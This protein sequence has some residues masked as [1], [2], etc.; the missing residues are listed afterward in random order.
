MDS[1]NPNSVR[2]L[3][4]QGLAHHKS[5]RFAEAV[6]LYERVLAEDPQQYDALHLAGVALRQQ[7]QLEPALGFLQRAAQ[8]RPNLAQT[9]R[10]LGA[11]LFG[12]KNVEASLAAL[13]RAIQLQPNSPDAY[14]YLGHVHHESGYF[15]EAISRYQKALSLDPQL[16]GYRQNIEIIRRREGVLK[17]FSEQ[18]S[19][20]LAGVS[21]PQQSS[22][23][24]LESR[25]VFP[26]LLNKLGLIGVGA[27]VGVQEGNY[28]E[29]LLNHWKGRLLYSIDPW[30]EFSSQ[31]YVDVA[32]VQ[33]SRHD[34]YYKG[35]IR[36]LRRFQGRSI[37]WRLTSQQAA[38]LIADQSLDFCYIDA[39]HSYEGVRDDIRLWHPKVK[40]GGILG[41]HDYIQDGTHSFGVFGVRRAVTEFVT[42][43][44]AE[45][46]VSGESEFAFP[47]WFVL[48]KR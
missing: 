24:G 19:S 14:E 7:G 37:I 27:E 39:D 9:H 11:V 25:N 5:N 28:S 18:C 13:Q 48:K 30:R 2:E 12:L 23:R 46:F 3:L 42:S 26:H 29:H 35:T 33:Q 44:G 36:R 22:G 41:G 17:E 1:S 6:A 45:F 38:D 32:N 20:F 4:A 47:S 10:E 21:R 16:P 43:E 40:A 31:Q 8:V 15:D 34:D